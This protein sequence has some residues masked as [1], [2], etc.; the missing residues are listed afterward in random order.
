[1]IDAPHF[2]TLVRVDAQALES[3]VVAGWLKPNRNTAGCRFAET[4]L[5]RAHLIRELRQTLA[6]NDEGVTAVLD[7]LDQ[8][9]D[10]Q[11]MLHALF[12]AARA[13]P[14][15]VQRCIAASLVRSPHVRR[16]RSA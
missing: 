4:D 1:M 9:H 6:L 14:A 3:W 11:Q 2:L 15:P 7:L 5:P 10:V 8:I 13:L 16:D 12:S